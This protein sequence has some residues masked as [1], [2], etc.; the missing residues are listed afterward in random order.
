MSNVELNFAFINEITGMLIENALF[1]ILFN[2]YNVGS[3][4]KI[5]LFYLFLYFFQNIYIY[6]KLIIVLPDT[7]VVFIE[8]SPRHCTLW[9]SFNCNENQKQWC[10]C[11]FTKRQSF[12][13]P[14][15]QVDRFCKR[16]VCPP[17]LFFFDWCLCLPFR[18]QGK[19]WISSIRSK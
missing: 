12:S 14:S 9:W 15:F 16:P 2:L 13:T 18:S 5:Y 19:V 8:L 4:F 10:N 3:P 17:A 1:G 11:F 6:F 7:R